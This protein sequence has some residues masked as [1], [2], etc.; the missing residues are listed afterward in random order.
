MGLLEVQE[1]PLVHFNCCKSLISAY[2]PE[3]C[4]F[5]DPLRVSV[6]IFCDNLQFKLVLTS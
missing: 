4:F 2:H 1:S 5:N 6:Q 3:P